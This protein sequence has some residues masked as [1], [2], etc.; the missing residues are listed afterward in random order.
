MPRTVEHEEARRQFNA[1]FDRNNYEK[2]LRDLDSRLKYP[3][4]F[5]VSET[6]LF[7]SESF[8]RE[9]VKATEEILALLRQDGFIR[10]ARNAMPPGVLFP[11]ED[12]HPTL[13]QI[14]FGI[15]RDEQGEFVPRLIELQ[16]FPSLYCFQTF[17]HNVL[18]DHFP[19]PPGFSPYF[20]GL[21][22]AAYVKKL[23]EVVV[24]DADPEETILLEIQPEQQK[25]R[26]DFA[27][28]EALL[29][30]KTVSVTEVRK[31]GRALSYIRNGRETR[32]RRIYNRVVFDEL[33]RKK[34]AMEFS[35]ADE[36]D[37]TWVP[38]PSWYYRLSKHTLPYL[39]SRYVPESTLLSALDRVPEDLAHYV[40]KPLYS[41]A[42]GG[43][44]VDVS[45]QDL[46]NVTD[47][48]AWILQRK[49]DYAAFVP[50]E[51]EPSKAEIRVMILWKDTPLLA[52][53][54]VRMSKG[55]MMGVDFNKDRTWVGSSI[56]YLPP[57]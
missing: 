8:S 45:E 3:T 33:S 34:P 20:S 53:N 18:S 36:L 55:K 14:D 11:R 1:A 25:T 4:D 44:I 23:H 17:F 29:G 27:A 48:S 9:L 5:R 10:Y 41:F 40:L 21:S 57:L 24:G 26:I 28:T 22:G 56:A 49:V 52:T 39:K 16:G 31:Q 12:P 19:L 6:P 13:L 43:V 38:H 47:P 7:L 32:I 50:T 37:I 2:F 15:T 46:R 35:F 30:V 54:L 42:G 51:D